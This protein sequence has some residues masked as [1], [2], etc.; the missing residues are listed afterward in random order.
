MKKYLLVAIN[1]QYIHTN[2]A[3]RYLKKYSEEYTNKNVQIY[4]TNV[5]NQIL[6][7][8]KEIHEQEPAVVI[9]STYIWNR[10]YVFK[11]IKELRK[12]M[13]ELKIGVGGPEATYMGDDYLLKDEQV[14]FLIKGEGERAFVKLLEEEN[15]DIKGIY[16]EQMPHNLDEIPFPYS[17]DEIMKESKILYYESS[18]GCPFSC[19]YCLS[20]IDKGVRYFSIDRVKKDLKI[21]LESNIKLLKF[22]D[23]TFNINKERYLEIWKYL[24][25]NYREGITFHF[26]INA[27]ILDDESLELLKKV[28]KDYFQF[29]IGVQSINYDTMESIN[30]RNL[31]DKLEKNVRE[32]SKNIHLHLDLIAGL[33]YETYDI[34]K[35]SFNYVYDLKPEMIQLGFLKILKGTNMEKTSEKYGYQYIEFPPYEVLYND[36]L[37]YKEIVR[38]KEVEKLL[39]YYYNSEKF[40]KSLNYII[41]KYYPSSFE[42]FEDISSFFKMSGLLDIGHKEL[43]LFNYFVDFVKYK[44]FSDEYFYEYLKFDYLKNGK[45]G[46]YPQWFK[47]EKDSDLYDVTIKNKGYKTTRDGHKNSELEIFSFNVLRDEENCERVALFFDYRNGKVYEVDFLIEENFEV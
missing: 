26:E 25:E 34:F 2:L 22:V 20:S 39:N 21:F 47:S 11:I 5:N 23:R 30:R 45:P 24:I 38:I 13:P 9:F 37:T 1:S 4:E 36:F 14:D 3:V 16:E 12:I 44:D 35:K 8:I 28:P 40:E 10:D 29:E 15:T 6:Q 18:R 43:S 33:P 19:S 32:I 41:K 17:L 42:F 46:V 7:I 27:N 31:L